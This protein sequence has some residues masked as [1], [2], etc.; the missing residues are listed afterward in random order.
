MAD[1]SRLRA[2]GPL[3]GHGRWLKAQGSWLIAKGGR[4]GPGALGRGSQAI[5]KTSEVHWLNQETGL[6]SRKFTRVPQEGGSR[7]VFW[8]PSIGNKTVSK[9]QVAKFE[10][11]FHRELKSFEVPLIESEIIR[12]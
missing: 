6:V 11:G 2:H 9:L 7:N 10:R 1:G 4:P 8:I 5:T 3:V 12:S